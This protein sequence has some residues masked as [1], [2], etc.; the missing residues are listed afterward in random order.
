MVTLCTALSFTVEGGDAQEL[1]S[2]RWGQEEGYNVPPTSLTTLIVSISHGCAL[3][4][5][6]PQNLSYTP[7]SDPRVSMTKGGPAGEIISLG[8]RKRA[9]EGMAG[10]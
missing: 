1:G 7:T 10:P 8:P 6:E 2:G 9:E 5:Y 3:E 4:C